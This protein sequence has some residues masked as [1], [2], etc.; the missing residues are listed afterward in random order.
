MDI[1]EEEYRKIIAKQDELAN[2]VQILQESLRAVSKENTLLKVDINVLKDQ[3]DA[4]LRKATSKEK[5]ESDIIQ[6]RLDFKIKENEELVKKI[7][8]LNLIIEE[9]RGY[10][11]KYNDL[12]KANKEMEQELLF[13]KK[14]AESI[15]K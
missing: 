13:L 9:L 7:N 1:S 14:S 6:Q 8:D 3:L 4:Q 12:I 15:Q 11:K 2:Q 10:A 5:P